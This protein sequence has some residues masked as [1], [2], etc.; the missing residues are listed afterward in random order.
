MEDVVGSFQGSC[1]IDDQINT[2]QETPYNTAYIDSFIT[3]LNGIGEVQLL[4]KELEISLTRELREARFLPPELTFRT[5]ISFWDDT[6]AF[7]TTTGEGI[8]WAVE[9]RTLRE[10]YQQLFELLWSIS[11]TMDSTLVESKR[12]KVQ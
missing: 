12:N 7:F 6:V 3:Y 1:C 9:S 11:A 10:T 8:H 5:S 4:T 2:V